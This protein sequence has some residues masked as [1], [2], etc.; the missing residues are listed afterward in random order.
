MNDFDLAI[1]NAWAHMFS[2]LDSLKQESLH[3]L[4]IETQPRPSNLQTALT[5][6]PPGHTLLGLY[7]QNKIILFEEP[8]RQAAASYNQSVEEIAEQVMRHE[9]WQH[10]FGTNHTVRPNAPKSLDETYSRPA[11]CCPGTGGW[12]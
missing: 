1:Q 6:T 3:N 5:Q 2:E 11:R 8:I 12:W 10:H 4:T 9:V 7:H